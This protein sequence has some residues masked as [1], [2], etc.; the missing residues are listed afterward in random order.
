MKTTYIIFTLI[1]IVGMHT[2]GQQNKLQTSNSFQ[3]GL[4]SWQ[5]GSWSDQK[6]TPAGFITVEQAGQDNSPAIRVQVDN[7]TKDAGKIFLRSLG[8]QIEKGKSYRLSFWVKSDIADPSIQAK[9]YSNDHTGSFK[10]WGAV[11]IEQLSF[12]GNGQWQQVTYDFIA[13]DKFNAAPA[14]YD[15]IALAFGFANQ[16]GIYFIDNISVKEI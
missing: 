4:Y 7:P 14:D 11:F 15:A 10:K 2:Y 12:I 6:E 8:V 5:Y 1:A 13:K 3:D 9:L 16:K